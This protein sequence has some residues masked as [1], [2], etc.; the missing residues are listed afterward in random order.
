MCPYGALTKLRKA[1]PQLTKGA[2]LDRESEKAESN[3]S[4]RGIAGTCA[5]L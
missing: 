5:R 1:L 2:T 3:L 4:W